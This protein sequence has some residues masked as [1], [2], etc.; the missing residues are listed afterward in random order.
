MPFV[1]LKQTAPNAFQLDLPAFARRAHGHD[2][3]NGSQLKKNHG[4][5]P[6]I[7]F[8]ESDADP[9]GDWDRLTS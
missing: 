5:T 3:F 8:L 6:K 1:V 9:L 7:D 4:A 2:V